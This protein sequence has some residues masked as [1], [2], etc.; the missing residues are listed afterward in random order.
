MLS[1]ARFRLGRI[2]LHILAMLGDRAVRFHAAGIM[3]ELA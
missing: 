1:L 3:R 2:L